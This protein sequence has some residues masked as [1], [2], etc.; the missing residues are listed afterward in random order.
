MRCHKC[1][2]S[3]NSNC[4]VVFNTPVFQKHHNTNSLLAARSFSEN[5]LNKDA[6]EAIMIKGEALKTMSREALVDF[7]NQYIT[8]KDAVLNKNKYSAGQS[9]DFGIIECHS[10]EDAEYLLRVVGSPDFRLGGYPL[11]GTLS[12]LNRESFYALYGNIDVAESIQERNYQHQQMI[13]NYYQEYFKQLEQAG[14]VYNPVTNEFVL[15]QDQGAF[16]QIDVSQQ[17]TADIQ[18]KPPKIQLEIGTGNEAAE[19]QEE[20]AQK[21]AES[22]RSESSSVKADPPKA[23]QENQQQDD[24]EDR[25]QLQK[26]RRIYCFTCKRQ[27]SRE[28]DYKLHTAISN[29]HKKLSAASI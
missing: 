4:R 6:C 18:M 5:R 3:K 29:L 23:S 22:D 25:E 27:F 28:A 17:Q 15:A 24:P 9:N 1:E 21:P 7:F 12:K 11:T 16:Q 8:V 26:K 10:A 13:Q 14:Y 19:D 2:N 20:E